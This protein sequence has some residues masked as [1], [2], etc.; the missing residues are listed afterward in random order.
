MIKRITY[1]PLLFAAFILS[2]FLCFPRAGEPT[3]KQRANGKN[4]FAIPWITGW[5][6][7]CV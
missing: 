7:C 3:G 2:S 6:L 4:C 5:T 1:L